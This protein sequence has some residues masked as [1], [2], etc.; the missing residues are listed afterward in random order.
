MAGRLAQDLL[1]Q[2][3]LKERVLATTRL[4]PVGTA[5][6]G[7]AVGLA[8]IFMDAA[9]AHG[10]FWENDPYWTYWVTK[11]FLITTVFTLGTAFIGVGI[12][13][14]LVLTFV[15]TLVLE[16]YYQWMAPIGLP[17]ETQ[18]LSFYDLWQVGFLVHYLT[19]LSGYLLALW[20]WRRVPRTRP[21][22]ETDTRSVA[23][24]A[25][26]GALVIVVVDAIL[27]QTILMG[28]WP[29]LTFY[30]QRLLIAFVLLFVWA[31]YVGFARS[32]WIVASLILS[33]AWTTYH[34]YLS[35][36]GSPSELPLMTGLPPLTEVRFMGYEDLWLRNF[37]GAIVSGLIGLFLVA[38]VLRSPID[39]LAREVPRARE[40]T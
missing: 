11:T 35:P 36:S 27:T 7:I 23:F 17:Q 28:H 34:M 25:L 39:D 29:G 20:I 2:R 22:A 24:L 32:G 9:V 6:F 10:L 21:L 5:Q 40:R 4:T 1:A 16:I 37:P 30:V 15:H 18:W 12:W 3:P 38:R 14:G 26:A 13:Q 33:L 8:A 19:I 31:S